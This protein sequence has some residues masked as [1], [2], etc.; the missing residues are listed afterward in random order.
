MII[1]IKKFPR[2]FQN[3]SFDSFI[4]NLISESNRKCPFFKESKNEETIAENRFPNKN[5][6]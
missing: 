3:D 4:Q 5:I 1:N 6:V 2:V